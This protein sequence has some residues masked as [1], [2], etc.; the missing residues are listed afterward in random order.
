MANTN[1]TELF[2]NI[3]DSIRAKD[4]T[5]DVITASDFPNKIDALSIGKDFGGSNLNLYIA[6]N[7]EDS[8]ASEQETLINSF[9]NTICQFVYSPTTSYTSTVGDEG[10][11]LKYVVSGFTDLIN[12][13]SVDKIQFIIWFAPP[14]SMYIWIKGMPFTEV[15]ESIATMSVLNLLYRSDYSKVF[16]VSTDNQIGLSLTSG[17]FYESMASSVSYYSFIIGYTD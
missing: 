13:G 16:L 10:T 1:L 9:K 12:I 6:T 15:S 3:A 11:G 17:K 2:T 8:K 14:S 4:G 5:T 7:G